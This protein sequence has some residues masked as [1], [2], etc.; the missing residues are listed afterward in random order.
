MNRVTTANQSQANLLPWVVWGVAA[1]F[2]AF[3][4]VLRVSP[5][6][7]A[8]ELMSA[9]K[10]EACALG[11]LI[12][13]YYIAYCIVQIPIGMLLDKLKPRR[14]ISLA[15]VLC[16]VGTFMFAMSPCLTV[17]AI[18]RA[19]IGAGSAAA[20]LGC[21]KVGTIWFPPRLLPRVVG[22]TFLLGSSGALM[23]GPPLAWLMDLLD[24]R[25]AL[26]VIG[27]IGVAVFLAIWFIVKDNSPYSYNAEPEKPPSWK[28]FTSVLQNKAGW[29][30]GIYSGLMYLPL[31]GFADMWGAPYIKSAYGV[32]NSSAGI[33]IGSFYLGIGLGAPLF[34]WI[35]DQ[36]GA[37]R[38]TMLLSSLLSLGFVSVALYMPYLP[39]SVLC[40]FLL[41]TGISL[42]GQFLG[43][44]V[45]TRINPIEASGSAC[46]FHN[47]LTMM[48]GV[49]AQPLM[50]WI[51]DVTW[52]GDIIN[53]VHQFTP[54]GYQ[55]SML[56]VPLG[57]A[58]SCILIKWI[59]E[60]AEPKQ[61]IS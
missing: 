36:L 38:P 55:L 45:A 17:A 51:L 19:L 20:L 2:Y 40:V 41:A 25:S 15:I 31:S 13:C 54:Y 24:W 53:G 23:A 22:L 4:F 11:A 14:T 37:F 26:I 52:A 5:S 49:V 35:N 48:S 10:V 21:L 30:T 58:A 6:F 50:G 12:S 61:P 56:I 16:L 9:F 34:S 57:L 28:T 59:P 18:G 43:Y 27:F 42:G 44:T 3:Q 1:L 60:V 29:I 32:D 46:G 33:A 47:M 7:M 8:D 39:F